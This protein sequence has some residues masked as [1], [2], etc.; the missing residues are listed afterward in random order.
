MHI[1]QRHHD[2][3]RLI[4]SAPFLATRKRK[5]KSSVIHEQRTKVMVFARRQSD[6]NWCKWRGKFNRHIQ[7]SRK[8]KHCG[9]RIS[10]PL[11]FP[12]ENAHWHFSHLT[13]H[14]H[15]ADWMFWIKSTELVR[16]NTCSHWAKPFKIGWHS[17]QKSMAILR[18]KN[19]GRMCVDMGSTKAQN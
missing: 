11:N 13:T 18:N 10:R 14:A 1:P 9:Y 4:I 8:K 3:F 16:L 6:V 12:R 7:K 15:A 5:R 19:V 2:I 17:E